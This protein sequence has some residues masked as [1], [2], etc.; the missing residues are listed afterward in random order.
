MAQRIDLDRETDLQP[1]AE[2]QP[3]HPVEQRLPMPVA[4]EIVVGDEE[5]LDPLRII[6]A[7]RA[8]EI[9]GGAEPALAPLYVDDRAERALVGAAAP[10]IEARQRTGDPPDVARRQYRR[11]L[12]FERRQI[13]HEIVERLQRAVAGVAQ[14]LV[15]PTLLG[16]AG[17]ERDAERLRRAHFRRHLGQ[18]RDRA[19]DVKAADAHRQPGGQKRPRQIDGARKLVGLHA[20]HR[21][22]RAAALADGSRG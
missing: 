18:H 5:P 8:F 9:V 10:E 16:L 13:V 15:E 12:A 2:P 7:D 11:R 17:K 1:L 6:L 20:D 19:R 14:H 3:D 21:D 4:R 22:Q